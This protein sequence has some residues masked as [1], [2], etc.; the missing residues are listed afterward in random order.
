M[1]SETSLKV[2]SHISFGSEISKDLL[3]QMSKPDVFRSV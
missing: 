3:N 1:H 2:K